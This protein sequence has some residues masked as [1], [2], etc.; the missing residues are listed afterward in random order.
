MINNDITIITSNTARGLHPTVI[1]FLIG[2]ES[3]ILVSISQYVYTHPVIL[4]LI[5]MSQSMTLL[6][7]EQGVYSHP[8]M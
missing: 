5:A 6:P 1:L 3:M 7:V 8:V 4:I 2:R